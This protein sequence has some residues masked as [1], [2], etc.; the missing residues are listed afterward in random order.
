MRMA[1]G[2]RA[3]GLPDTRPELL[4]GIGRSK[5]DEHTE[6][7]RATS[8][9]AGDDAGHGSD[10]HED[11]LHEGGLHAGGL[12]AGRLHGGG[13]DRGG[14]TASRCTSMDDEAQHR[15]TGSDELMGVEM[16]VVVRV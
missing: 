1:C 15:T 3:P 8:A 9:R 7:C 14:Y 16:H 2:Y 13:S 6:T 12:H 4:A 5:D 11:G 10:L